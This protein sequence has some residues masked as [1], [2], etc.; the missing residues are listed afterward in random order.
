M[1][2]YIVGKGEQESTLHKE[3]NMHR[4]MYHM[5]ATNNMYQPQLSTQFEF[6]VTNLEGLPHITT[7]EEIP[8]VQETLRLA[9]VRANIPHFSQTPIVERRANSVQKFAG[10]PEFDEGEITI[11]DWIGADTKSILMS[12]QNQ[13]YDVKTDKIG[14][15]SDYQRD[16]W[17]IE[18]TPDWQEVRKWILEGCWISRI[19]ED[20]YDH[21]NNTDVRQITATIQYNR[22][23]LDLAD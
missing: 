2:I 13:S 20:P 9:V 10:T 22:A 6:V 15:V 11:R 17:L 14:L 12:W 19:S 1:A 3:S 7:G 5:V 4:G 16:C 21:G 18:Y 8:D 23:Y